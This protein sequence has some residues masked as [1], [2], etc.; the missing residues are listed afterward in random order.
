MTPFRI[1]CTPGRLGPPFPLVALP[2]PP[3]SSLA[4]PPAR[5]F[6]LIAAC[7]WLP[8]HV[9]PSTQNAL[10]TFLGFGFLLL[11]SDAISPGEHALIRAG[12][13]GAK[14]TLHA[15]NTLAYHKHDISHMG[16]LSSLLDSIPSY[17]GPC[18]NFLVTHRI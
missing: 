16:C 8:T 3:A 1:V 10:P 11:S 18:F 6:L 17:Q 4:L 12:A 5:H 15:P 14:G 7:S 2:A 13:G 9:I